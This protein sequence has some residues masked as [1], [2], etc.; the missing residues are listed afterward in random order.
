MYIAIVG[1]GSN[2]EPDINVN[3]VKE[4]V[5]KENELLRSSH[6]LMTEPIGPVKQAKY[7]NGAGFMGSSFLPQRH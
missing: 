4:I 5:A 1:V 6:F 2:I 3:K 7:L